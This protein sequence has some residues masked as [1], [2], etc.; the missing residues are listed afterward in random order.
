MG[1]IINILPLEFVEHSHLKFRPITEFKDK[2]WVMGNNYWFPILEKICDVQ[3]NLCETDTILFIIYNGQAEQLIAQP[4]YFFD[5]KK[6]LDEG[7]YKKVILFQNEVNWDTF[8]RILDIE[9]FFYGI[10]RDDT[11]FI[12]VRNIFKSK[13]NFT[14]I[15]S[16]FSFG[17]F[18][19]QLLYNYNETVEFENE[20]NYRNS[21]K[22][23]KPFEKT[24]HLFSAN[25]NVKEERLHLYQ[26]LEK[27]NYWDKSNVSFFLPLYNRNTKRFNIQDF[28]N[29]NFLYANVGDGKKFISHLGEIDLGIN[30]FP[31]KMKYDNFH[32]VKNL[33]LADSIESVFQ[34]IF[35]TRYHSHCGLVLSEKIFKGFLYKTPFLVFAQ[36]GVLKLLKELGFKTFDW[37]VDE[38]YDYEPD[39]RKRL[40][41]VFEETKKLFDTPIHVLN[42]KIKLHSDDFEH[43]RKLVNTFALSE[44]DKI[45]KLFDVQ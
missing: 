43:N 12:F 35:E 13:F 17:C 6:K 33:A 36:Y 39:D 38:S 16:Q 5:V 37:L 30:Y 19:F 23:L 34:L 3:F 44:I 14:K 42:E 31:K 11:R 26:F 2:E 10:F 7:V 15:N 28:I 1:N 20:L 41:L 4:E 21:S 24:Y 27:N 40:N 8:E 9:D 22:L 32:Q 25:C 18:P 45:Y 29:E